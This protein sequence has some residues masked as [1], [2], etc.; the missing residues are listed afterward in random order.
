[1]KSCTSED[2]AHMKSSDAAWRFD[3]VPITGDTPTIT[4]DGWHRIEWANCR[5]CGSTL[6]R[7]LDTRSAHG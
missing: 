3:T 2:H 4:V 6:I 1:M 5:H 7:Y